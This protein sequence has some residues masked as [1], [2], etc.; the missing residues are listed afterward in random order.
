D[1]GCNLNWQHEHFNCSNHLCATNNSEEKTINEKL[2]FDSKE[3]LNE[4]N[5]ILIMNNTLKEIKNLSNVS[6][7]EHNINIVADLIVDV[8]TIKLKVD[9]YNAKKLEADIFVT[10]FSECI[11][12]A[13]FL[14][15]EKLLNAT[16]KISKSLE[17]FMTKQT[18][19]DMYSI[20][21]NNLSVLSLKLNV[22]QQNIS[23]FVKEINST[24]IQLTNSLNGSK[25]VQTTA[26]L[27]LNLTNITNEST[28]V[29][30]AVYDSS[31]L[32]DLNSSL[33]QTTNN[34]SILNTSQIISNV[35]SI[36][37]NQVLTSDENFVTSKFR[38]LEKVQACVQNLSK[39]TKFKC[40]FW[41]YSESKWSTYGCVYSLSVDNMHVCKC[42]HLTNFAILMSFEPEK[43]SN[44]KIC[45]S[46][47]EYT[48]YIGN[49]LSMIGLLMTS[50]I[51]LYDKIDKLRSRRLNSN[52]SRF[53]QMFEYYIEILICLTISLLLMNIFYVAFSLLKW[54]EH[55]IACVSIG[56]ALHYTLLCSFSWMLSFSILQYFTFNKVLV[57]IQNY[58][59]KAVLFSLGF[60]LIPIIIILSMNWSIY[61]NSNFSCW[62]SGYSA[63]F[64]IITPLAVILLINAIIFIFIVKKHCFT[65]KKETTGIKKNSKNQTVILSTCFVNM[66]LTWI[67]GFLLLIDLG[68]YLRLVFSLLF[69]IFNSLQGFLIFLIYILLS[70]SRRKNLR[71]KLQQFRICISLESD[72]KL[73]NNLENKTSLSDVT[74][75]TSEFSF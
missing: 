57:T 26:L 61:K 66:G 72:I 41:D 6:L 13:D 29:S 1:F 4:N 32:F 56:V 42:N 46:I 75:Q 63:I 33:I 28:R 20:D 23:G 11:D 44:C 69:C 25:S 37:S 31:V 49:F 68:E 16:Q 73:N 67:F 14:R 24:G 64:G 3:I 27:F 45:D 43:I 55:L 2:C 53:K 34:C 47:L 17:R 48:T 74:R 21:T 65:I 59:S 60:P 50:A 70:K 52:E 62:P 18:I 7:S 38:P 71:K 9:Q 19:P 12:Q 39:K 58:F 8:S 10:L 22:N 15:S 36:S 54:N 5:T 51:Y 30:F 35:V 40:V